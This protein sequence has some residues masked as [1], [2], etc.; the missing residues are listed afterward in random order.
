MVRHI[1]CGT[2]V[3]ESERLAAERLQIRLREAGGAWILLSN[4][5]HAQHPS[6]RSDEID[7]VV[8]GPPGVFVIEVKHWDAAYLRQNTQVAE[9]EADR[10]DAKAKRVA[11][12]LRLRLD[13]GFVAARLLLTRGEVR[14][15]ATKRPSPRGVGAFGLPEWSDLLAA[16]G[17]AQ[18]GP[19]QIELAARLLEPSVKDVPLCHRGGQQRRSRGRGTTAYGVATDPRASGQ[20]R[21]P[22]VWG[23]SAARRRVTLKGPH[24]CSAHRLRGVSPDT[25]IAD[26]E[27]YPYCQP[28]PGARVAWPMRSARATLP[29]LVTPFELMEAL[30]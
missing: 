25:G 23:I 19:D 21:D 26:L 16:G 7:I 24:R 22:G 12:K 8:I 17:R 2:F 30:P 10:I 14:F 18:L 20:P 27:L 6:A 11:G 4:L 29:E 15:D 3:N 9:R 28:R 1:P 5:N 13:P